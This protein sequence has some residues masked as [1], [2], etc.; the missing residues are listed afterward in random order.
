MQW[1]EWK[2]SL[3]Y[4]RCNLSFHFLLMFFDHFFSFFTMAVYGSWRCRIHIV[5][6]I[7]S[8]R[9][10]IIFIVLKSNISNS[11]LLRFMFI[12]SENVS[13]DS[14]DI[15]LGVFRSVFLP[16]LDVN[17]SVVIYIL[18]LNEFLLVSID[19]LIFCKIC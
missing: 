10:I 7:S 5:E 13:F 18:I 11:F 8:V 15:F 14:I 19:L 2:L 3:S 17:V 9:E 1:H 6:K 4:L 16:I 12:S